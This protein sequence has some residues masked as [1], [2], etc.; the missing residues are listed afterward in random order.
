MVCPKADWLDKSQKLLFWENSKKKLRNVFVAWQY[1]PPV[2]RPVDGELD[3]ESLGER[4]IDDKKNNQ[5]LH[6]NKN[7]DKRKYFDK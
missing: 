4:P 1:W 3:G 5:E 7:P 2:L 6:K